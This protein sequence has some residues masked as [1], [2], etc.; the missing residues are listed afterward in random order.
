M[1]TPQVAWDVKGNKIIFNASLC[2]G[3]KMVAVIG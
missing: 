3:I 1:E 2:Q